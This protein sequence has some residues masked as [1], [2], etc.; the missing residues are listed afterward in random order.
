LR[1][2]LGRLAKDRAH[3]E[4]ARDLFEATGAA[5]FAEAARAALREV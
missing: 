1:L 5:P 3:L 2:S 4:A